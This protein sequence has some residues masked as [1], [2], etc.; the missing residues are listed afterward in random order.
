MNIS[1]PAARSMMLNK[2]D[3]F[4]KASQT[5]GKVTKSTTQSLASLFKEVKNSIEGLSKSEQRGAMNHLTIMSDKLLSQN[6][7]MLEKKMAP[8]AQ[9]MKAI[10]S[11][12]INTQKS[13]FDSAFQSAAGGR[14]I[15]SKY[16]Q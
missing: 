3:S 4:A 9:M 12:G 8:I 13:A 6:S 14:G 11:V 1:G 10:N 7:N 2:L 5:D 15:A 16:S